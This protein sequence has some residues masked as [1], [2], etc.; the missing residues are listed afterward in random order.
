MFL[1]FVAIV[2]FVTSVFALLS[3]ADTIM[4]RSEWIL[5]LFDALAEDVRNLGR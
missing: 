2:V 3:L 1:D 5:G 4:E